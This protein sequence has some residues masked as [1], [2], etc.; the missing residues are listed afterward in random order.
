MPLVGEGLLTAGLGLCGAI[1]VGALYGARS[2][3]PHYVVHARRGVYALAAI[4]AVAM[5]L[6]Q[7]AYLRSDFSIALVAQ[8][9][10]SDTPTFFKLTALWT[11]QA[12]SLLLWV[13]LLAL[14]S[15]VVLRNARGRLERAT[16]YAIAV[17]ATVAAFFMSLIV[18]FEPPF[19]T[20]SPAPAEGNG[21]NPL[22]RNELNAIHPPLLYAGYVGF[23]IPFAFAI[24]A[25]ITRETGA[26][27]IRA[28]RRYALAAWS[29]LAA[30]LLIGSYWG[31]TELGWGGYWGWD[32]VENAALL[33]WLTGT[34][35]IHS[36]MV[37]E[38]RG[39]LRIWNVT[40][41]IGTFV[42]ALTG[43][44]LVRS[45]ILESVHAFGASTLGV[46]FLVFIAI[47]VLGSAALVVQRVSDLRS[48]GRLESLLSREAIFLFNNL[49]LVGLAF[50][51]F[52]GTFFPLISEAAT[53][54]RASLGTPWFEQYTTPLALVLALLAG[55]GPAFAWGRISG[56][57][58]R[59]ALI[60]PLAVAAIGAVATVTLA[61]AGRRPVALLMFALVAF[62]V[63][64]A[65]QEFARGGA[66]VRRLHGLGWPR[67]LL[68]L[69]AINRRRYGGYIAHVGIA[70]LFLGA[71]ASSSFVQRA[72]AQLE[73]G[74]TTRIGAYTVTY[75]EPT[76]T[77][78]DD[79][80]RTGAAITLGAVLDVRRGN[81]RFTLRPRRNYY[82][83][84]DI[85]GLGATGRF[86]GG[87]STTEVDLDVGPGR[88]MWAAL[89]P[90]TASLTDAI[91]LADRRFAEPSAEV[92]GVILSALVERYRSAPGATTIRLIVFPLVVWLYVGGAVVLLGALIA[93]SQ[94]RRP[95]A[96]SAS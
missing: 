22:L 83:S 79:P 87:E 57:A 73:P 71:A 66:V 37:Q 43:T 61:D 44:F 6:L 36:V 25:L 70:V 96:S 7:V 65:A 55:L 47:V 69:I 53:G 67:A 10:S 31:Y 18:V 93:M 2:G 49:A 26:E 92:Q 5:L 28:T 78:F 48:T 13:F 9:S 58:L 8:N 41:I 88:D 19:A 21:M 40:L 42:L 3:R 1:A 20:L 24:G 85:E 64:V 80:A 45:G 4:L 35:F 82:P 56:A 90:D 74:E 27:W 54:N 68:R 32:P 81:R 33:P 60:I 11:S 62:V 50:V 77:L 59:R 12:G 51:I 63:A 72:D 86:F 52:W 39:M 34:A 30:G 23:A 89:Q 16:P 38:R 29:F 91:E 84:R 75:R 17:L 15:A 76:A 95:A 46:P 14:Y 94:R